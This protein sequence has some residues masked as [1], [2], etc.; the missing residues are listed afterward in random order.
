MY[1]LQPIEEHSMPNLVY[2]GKQQQLQLSMDTWTVKNWITIDS[3]WIIDLLYWLWSERMIQHTRHSNKCNINWIISCLQ[4]LKTTPHQIVSL[5]L[6]ERT[7]ICSA[8]T[9][10]TIPINK[11]A[12][13]SFFEFSWIL[14]KYRYRTNT[15]RTSIV[16]PVLL[17]VELWRG[18][19]CNG[20]LYLPYANIHMIRIF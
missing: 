6:M 13:K 16:V 20:N 18:E 3:Q 11:I 14:K 9:Y 15:S 1:W 10:C 7:P 5:I 8:S 12:S 17:C 2:G 19:H 4:P